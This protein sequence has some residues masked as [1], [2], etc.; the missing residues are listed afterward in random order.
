[1]IHA[2]LKHGMFGMSIHDQWINDPMGFEAA[3]RDWVIEIEDH[4]ATKIVAGDVGKPAILK[5]MPAMTTAP[6]LL[7]L[8]DGRKAR[9]RKA[10]TARPKELALHITVATVLRDHC[11]PDW[12]WTH[13]NRKAKDAREGAIL[14]TMGVKPDWPDFILISPQGSVR[15]LELKRKGAGLNAGQKEFRIRNIRRG[16]PH[17]VAWTLDQALAAF[18]EWGCLRIVLPK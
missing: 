18:S 2:S 6:P 10:P 9:R 17:V 12:D 11:L 7:V 1:M 8:A 13:I 15:H 16:I 5:T 4:H 3:A 14:K